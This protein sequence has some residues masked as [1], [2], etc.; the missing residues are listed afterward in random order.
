LWCTLEDVTIMTNYRNCLP[1]RSTWSMSSPPDFSGVRV[2]RS[3]VLCVM[4]CRSFFWP[5]CCLFFDL[6]IPITHLVSSNSSYYMYSERN[7]R[8]PTR[9]KWEENKFGE[10]ICVRT[11]QSGDHTSWG[12]FWL[13]CTRPCQPTWWSSFSVNDSVNFFIRQ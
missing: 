13:F 6:R 4:F 5:L 1:F 8:S 11:R 3:L 2:T 7:Y 10:Y 12:E 9:Q